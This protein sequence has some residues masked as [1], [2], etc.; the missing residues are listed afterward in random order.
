MISNITNTKLYN[1][2]DKKKS[3][4]VDLVYKT[5]FPIQ[6]TE[7]S[8][9]LKYLYDEIDDLRLIK[10]I[11]LEIKIL[12]NEILEK[13]IKRQS[14]TIG[15]KLKLK[16]PKI[17]YVYKDFSHIPILELPPTIR[18]EKKPLRKL[19]TIKAAPNLFSKELILFWKQAI[20]SYLEKINID[21]VLSI[22]ESEEE[23]VL[24]KIEN[25]S[26]TNF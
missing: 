8:L 23:T 15:E 14:V 6:F 10:L 7:N 12:E 2:L 17:T 16:T 13:K 11:L 20:V 9:L 19:T 1:L 18:E 5:T 3:L 4:L 26:K 21:K 24:R 22:L 25:N